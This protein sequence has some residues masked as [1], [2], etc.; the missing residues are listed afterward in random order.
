MLNPG[1]RTVHAGASQEG[2]DLVATV[3]GVIEAGTSYAGIVL[4]HLGEEAAGAAARKLR[5]AAV[6]EGKQETVVKRKPKPKREGP[7]YELS[8]L[9]VGATVQAQ[10]CTA[11]HQLSCAMLSRLALTRLSTAMGVVLA[12]AA[13]RSRR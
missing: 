3:S 6:K 11:T 5:H 4:L 2:D 1:V 13:C 7:V 12:A 10:V 9:V 8:E